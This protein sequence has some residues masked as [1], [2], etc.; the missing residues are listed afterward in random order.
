MGGTQPNEEGIRNV[1][2]RTNYQVW[3]ELVGFERMRGS[4]YSCQ[5]MKRIRESYEEV[6]LKIWLRDDGG[7]GFGKG[8]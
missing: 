3:K 2:G 8:D 4:W 5:G 6:I 7:L 1:P